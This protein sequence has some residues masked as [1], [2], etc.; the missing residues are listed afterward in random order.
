MQEWRKNVRNVMPYVPGEQPKADKVIKLN[1]NE[2][3]YPPA[4]GVLECE[5][6]MDIT[7]LRLYPDPDASLLV[8]SIAEYYGVDK[9][10]VFVGVG[11]DDV[12]AMSFLTF[13]NSDKP[14]LFLILHI[15]SMM[16]GPSY[17][18]FRMY[19]L[20]LKKILQ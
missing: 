10:E 8:G 9:S 13:F 14:I 3:P 17:L 4:P 16:Y 6:N 11:S 15:L 1:T 12:L 2:N 18:E 20:L 7:A 19:V 5:R